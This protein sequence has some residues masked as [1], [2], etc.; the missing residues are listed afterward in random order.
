[1]NTAA[2]LAIAG[3]KFHEQIMDDTCTITRATANGS[4]PPGTLPPSGGLEPGSGVLDET[5]GL[6]TVVP[7]VIYTGPCRVVNWPRPPKDTKTVGQ[8]E[9]ATNARLDLPVVESANV[10]DGDMVELDTSIDPGLVGA[11]YRLR[12]LAGQTHGTA[13]RFFVEA[14]T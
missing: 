13:R 10:R 3:R 7:A 9:A 11:K 1:M 14:Y 8:V 6:Y 4:L 2:S 5:T 12:G